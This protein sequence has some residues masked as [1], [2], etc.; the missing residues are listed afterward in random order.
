[1][2]WTERSN[3]G[4]TI[5]YWRLRA[6]GVLERSLRIVKKQHSPKPTLQ[7]VKKKNPL[8]VCS[9]GLISSLPLPPLHRSLMVLQ[10]ESYNSQ[11][12]YDSYIMDTWKSYGD[13]SM[14]D[15]DRAKTRLSSEDDITSISLLCDPFK[16][17][18]RPMTSRWRRIPRRSKNGF[19]WRGWE[20][21]CKRVLSLVGEAQNDFAMWMNTC[22]FPPSVR[23]RRSRSW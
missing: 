3:A 4:V 10:N 18:P 23:P 14:V 16:V 21:L 22:I 19:E 9:T 11:R 7:K 6:T 1:M 15:P 8:Y 2:F 13:G 20:G 12:F 5:H 17:R